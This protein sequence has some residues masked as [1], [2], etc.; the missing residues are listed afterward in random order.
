MD[1]VLVA[2]SGRTG[3]RCAGYPLVCSWRK[4]SAGADGF[5]SHFNEFD[6]ERTAIA[7][8]LSH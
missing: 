7:L 1:P 8:R 6:A 5:D 4:L 3:D 2:K